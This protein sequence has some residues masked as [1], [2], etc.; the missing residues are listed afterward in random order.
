MLLLVLDLYSQRSDRSCLFFS[1]FDFC[2]RLSFITAA[3][4]QQP[5]FSLNGE[6]AIGLKKKKKK[7]EDL[8]LPFPSTSLSSPEGN[9]VQCAY[10]GIPT[11]FDSPPVTATILQVVQMFCPLFQHELNSSRLCKRI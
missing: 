5:R 11:K 6:R 10:S 9:M 2:L 4:I 7:K 3:K 1:S 8:T